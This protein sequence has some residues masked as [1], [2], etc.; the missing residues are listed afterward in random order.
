[1]PSYSNSALP[2]S[3][4]QNGSRHRKPTAGCILQGQERKELGAAERESG[5][6]RSSL[7]LLIGLH[8][9]VLQCTE[10][11]QEQVAHSEMPG[12]EQ[13]TAMHGFRL[14]TYLIPL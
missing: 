4:V 13:S 9:T 5:K 14:E 12:R 8:T 2:V 7:G 6:G 1:M 11:L 10:F 3:R